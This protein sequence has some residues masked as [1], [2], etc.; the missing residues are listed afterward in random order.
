MCTVTV[1]LVS[2]TQVIEDCCF[3]PKPEPQEDQIELVLPDPDLIV[4]IQK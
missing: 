4:C 1:M 3:A 2:I